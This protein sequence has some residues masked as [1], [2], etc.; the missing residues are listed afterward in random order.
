[1]QAHLPAAGFVCV[2]CYA[3]SFPYRKDQ[4]SALLFGT[5][6][7]VTELSVPDLVGTG[8]PVAVGE[9]ADMVSGVSTVTAGVDNTIA[10][11]ISSRAA[12][13]LNPSG[14]RWGVRTRARARVDSHLATRPRLTRQLLSSPPVRSRPRTRLQRHGQNSGGTFSRRL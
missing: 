13:A 5:A 14:E 9:G 3:D 11:D 8:S 1:M 12:D 6:G 4:Y 7:P 2:A 10:P